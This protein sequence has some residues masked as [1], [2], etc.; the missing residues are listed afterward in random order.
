MKNEKKKLMITIAVT[1]M[2]VLAN[3]SQVFAA[4]TGLINQVLEPLNLLK[5][6]IF[7]GLAVVGGIIFAWN[8]FHFAGA[9]KEKDQI[10]ISSNLLGMLGGGIMAGIGAVVSFLGIG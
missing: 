8:A 9:L 5:T 1:A 2:T 4:D 6:L 3:T 10:G 7:A